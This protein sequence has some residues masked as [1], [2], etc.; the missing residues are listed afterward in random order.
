MKL[1]F[2]FGIGTAGCIGCIFTF[3]PGS[4]HGIRIMLDGRSFWGSSHERNYL[5]YRRHPDV[6]R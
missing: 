2:P 3:G 6:H 4:L 1:D 5:I